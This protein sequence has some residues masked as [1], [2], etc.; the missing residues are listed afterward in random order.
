MA[1]IPAIRGW[2]LRAHLPVRKYRT[3][4]PRLHRIARAVLYCIAIKYDVHLYEE[5]TRSAVNPPNMSEFRIC[6]HV[7]L[8][9]LLYLTNFSHTGVRPGFGT[10]IEQDRATHRRVRSSSCAPSATASSS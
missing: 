6:L 1:A 9:N 8:E 7:S 5:Q 4:V 3:P 10:K 2:Q